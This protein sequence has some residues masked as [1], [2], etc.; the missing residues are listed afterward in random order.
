MHLRPVDRQRI[1]N[2]KRGISNA[3]LAYSQACQS[4]CARVD[5]NVFGGRESERTRHCLRFSRADCFRG[6]DR[7]CN[8][9]KDRDWGDRDL[10]FRF[11]DRRRCRHYLCSRSR[12]GLHVTLDYGRSL[13]VAHVLSSL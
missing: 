13:L 1:H 2:G 3:S 5:L 11:E 8:S 7:F 6:T 9:L 12:F 4:G 10:C